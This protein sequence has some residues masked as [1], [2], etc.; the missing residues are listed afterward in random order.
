MM[1]YG[2]QLNDLIVPSPVQQIASSADWDRLVDAFERQ[3]E[4]IYAKAAKYP[5]SGFEIFEVGL[6]ATATKI[7][8][9]LPVYELGGIDPSSSA[10]LG[11]RPAW[12]DGERHDT[13]RFEL[14]AMR[15]GNQIEG[16]AVVHDRTTCLVVPPGFR[17]RVDEFK[18]FWLER[19]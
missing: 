11:T 1:R 12:F 2:R 19:A 7:K 14:R 8:P 3:Y 9:Q 10:R 13:A 6:V 17:V 16:P 15:S 18:T 4:K 5:Q